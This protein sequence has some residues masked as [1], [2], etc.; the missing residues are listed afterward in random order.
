MSRPTKKF[1]QWLLK[2]GITD[3]D[4]SSIFSSPGPI[5]EKQLETLK[6]VAYRAYK[7]GLNEGRDS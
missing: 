7:R 1:M 2:Y 6:Y 3:D 4:R 5:T